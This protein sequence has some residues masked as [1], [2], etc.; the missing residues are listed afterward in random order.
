M[1]SWL[2]FRCAHPPDLHTFLFGKYE[3]RGG[4]ERARHS[5]NSHPGENKNVCTRLGGSLYTSQPRK[6]NQKSSFPNLPW[7]TAVLCPLP[8]C[9]IERRAS[10]LAAGSFWDLLESLI[11]QSSSLQCVS[12]WHS[13]RGEETACR[14]APTLPGRFHYHD[15]PTFPPAC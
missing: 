3:T 7:F 13:R 11:F 5:T 14:H 8:S 12:R 4:R 9:V 15:K 2:A 1:V 6:G 10:S